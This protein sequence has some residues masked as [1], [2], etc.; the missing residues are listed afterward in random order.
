MFRFAFL[1]ALT[2]ALVFALPS[3]ADTAAERTAHATVE[4]GSIVVRGKPFFPVMLID[5][6]GAGAAGRA[7]RLG[8]NVILNE[9]C[10]SV[11]ARPQFGVLPIK[12]RAARGPRLLGFTY[13][14]EPD[15]NGWSPA[16]LARA[17]PYARGNAD[18]LLSFLT[19]TSGFF[20]GPDRVARSHRTEAFAKLADVAGFDLYPLNHCRSDLA[21]VYR[22]QRRFTQ[23]AGATPTFQWIETGA[24]HP[25][26]CG[27]LVITPEQV[28]AEAWLAV[29]GGARGVGFFTH[30]WSPTHSEFEVSPGVQGAIARF[31]TTA[32][33]IGPGLVGKTVR[34]GVDTPA[35][36]VL[37]RSNGGRTYVVAVNTLT[38]VVPAT[39][40]VPRLHGRSLQVVG[41][42]R[43]VAVYD[44]RFADTFAPLGVHVYAER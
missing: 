35:L 14:D 10:T 21:E 38:S 6:C 33:A 11:P 30:T 5:Q 16:G 2:G 28:T 26:Y 1:G 18:G 20:T 9:S 37:A 25:G 22:A 36:D 23:L 4:Q 12:A 39:F 43:N 17:F 27:G 29:A 34:S 24:I 8:V 42:N 44:H 40:T 7:S 15:N 3:L 41:E 19:T 31:A 32:S 13:P